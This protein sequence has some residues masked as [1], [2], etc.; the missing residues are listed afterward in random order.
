M[1]LFLAAC[2]YVTTLP[3]SAAAPAPPG[4]ASG[5]TTLTYAT[6]VQPILASDCVRCHGPSN[7]QADVDLSTYAAVRRILTP[8]DPSSLLIVATQPNGLMFNQFSGNRTAKATTI[9]DW[10]VSSGAAQ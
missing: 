10:I 6:D 9:H 5:S 1:I 8:G 3:P 7:H 4:T 2:K